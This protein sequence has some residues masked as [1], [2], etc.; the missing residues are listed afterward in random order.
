MIVPRRLVRLALCTF[1]LMIVFDLFPSLSLIL[2]SSR[3]HFPFRIPVY[4][5]IL[6]ALALSHLIMC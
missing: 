6:T 4:L 5:R 1:Y 2:F 3:L